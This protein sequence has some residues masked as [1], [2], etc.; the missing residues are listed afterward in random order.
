MMQFAMTQ[1]VIGASSLVICIHPEIIHR[2]HPRQ[3][4]Q[5]NVHDDDRTGH[6]NQQRNPQHPE[7]D[8]AFR[9]RLGRWHAAHGRAVHADQRT[10]GQRRFDVSGLSRRNPRPIG[11]LA[12]V[13]GFQ[14]HFSS[15][16]IY[17][18][19][20]TLDAL[21]VMNPAAL[22]TNLSD[23]TKGGI[24]IANLDNFEKKDC[25]MAGYD[26]NPLDSE[27]LE[28]T[29]QLFKVPMTKIVGD[30]L[31]DSRADDQ[32]KGPLQELLRPG[33][34]VLALR[35]RHGRRPFAT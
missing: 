5:Q 15:T 3:Y 31:K 28:H 2:Q 8:G 27:V 14:V 9:G 26:S 7:R 30:A 20:D 35:P 32:G 24:L 16:D 21:V 22:K 29:Y 19:G 23:L 25:D 34:G 4:S 13:S 11:T 10:L 17:T 33:P 6:R 12:G 1:L 18:P